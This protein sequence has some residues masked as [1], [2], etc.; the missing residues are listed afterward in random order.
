MNIFQRLIALLMS[1]LIPWLT[2]VGIIIKQYDQISGVKYGEEVSQVMDVY[3]PKTLSGDGSAVLFLHDGDFKSGARA[4]MDTDCQM[5][6]NKGYVA[7][8]MDYTLFTDPA[9]QGQ[10][11][12]ALSMVLDEITAAIKTLKNMAAEKGVN[13]KKLA[14]SGA[15]AGGYYALMYTYTRSAYANVSIQFVA[16]KGAHAD[17]SYQIWRDI[18]TADEFAGLIGMLAGVGLTANAVEQNTEALK[19]AVASVSPAAALSKRLETIPTL[20]AY[21]VKDELVPYANW[22]SLEGALTQYNIPYDFVEYINADHS[23]KH[24]VLQDAAYSDLLASYLSK[25]LI[26]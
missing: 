23:F 1:L 10:T 6:A 14:L 9:L 8:T 24:E 7:A 20:A 11:T 4:E 26:K 16:V 19:A 17:F 21:A 12:A 25:Y 5:I 15:G 18:C 22:V 13:L 2:S 3:I